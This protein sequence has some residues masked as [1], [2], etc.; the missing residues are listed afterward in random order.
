MATLAAE[1]LFP[2]HLSL[3]EGSALIPSEETLSH[4]SQ[5][6]LNNSLDYAIGISLL[7]WLSQPRT[8]A[9]HSK[10]YFCD[11]GEQSKLQDKMWNETLELSQLVTPKYSNALLWLGGIMVLPP[12]SL[13]EAAN[14]GGHK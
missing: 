6:I 1:I 14:S 9:F 2:T 8:Q 4:P 13:A 5:R 7:I 3:R 12:P 10:F 11:F